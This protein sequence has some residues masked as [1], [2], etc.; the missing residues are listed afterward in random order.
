MRTIV[1]RNAVHVL[2]RFPN[3]AR[4][5]TH[6]L[7]YSAVAEY[8]RCL[9]HKCERVCEQCVQLYPDAIIKPPSQ[10]AFS[11]YDNLRS[12]NKMLDKDVK[13][14]MLMQLMLNRG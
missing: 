3:Q 7:H 12:S 1:L 5:R 13:D 14:A 10:I 4:S 11:G 2:S 9:C 8:L 6:S